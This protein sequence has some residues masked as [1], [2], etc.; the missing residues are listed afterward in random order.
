MTKGKKLDELEQKNAELV[1]D[2]QRVRAD[3]ENYRK[4]V[5]N[6]KQAAMDAGR[7]KAVINLLPSID[8][9]ER[10]VA[11]IPED[12]AEHQW[13]KG[14]EALIRQLDKSLAQ[15][16]L[17][18]VVAKKGTLFDPELH[19]AI[20]FDDDAV[21]EKEVIAEELQPGYTLEGRVI[22]PAMVKVTRQS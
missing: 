8:T 10:A 7:T 19:Q 1:M 14:V 6:E 2:L 18:R 20:Q 11:H 12:I 22:R 13:V 9:I 15:L 21:G 3:F 16:N 4:M 5:E 17:Q